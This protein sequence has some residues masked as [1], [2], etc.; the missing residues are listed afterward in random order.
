MILQIKKRSDSF[1]TTKLIIHT[2]LCFIFFF[3]MLQHKRN[4]KKQTNKDLVLRTQNHIHLKYTHSIN[5]INNVKIKPFHN[6]IVNP[7][8]TK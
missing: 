1:Q 6:K 7:K 5:S 3:S 4:M 8:D 2:F